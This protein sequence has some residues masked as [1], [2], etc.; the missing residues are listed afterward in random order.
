LRKSLRSLRLIFLFYRKEREE[1]AKFTK[2]DKKEADFPEAIIEKRV[3]KPAIVG[4]ELKG[5]FRSKQKPRLP[6]RKA[7]RRHL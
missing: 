4:D 7:N 2:E 1:G 5:R 6:I 3:P